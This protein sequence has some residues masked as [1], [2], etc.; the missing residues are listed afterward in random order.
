M[1]ISFALTEKVH[2]LLEIFF[3]ENLKVFQSQSLSADYTEE[4]FKPRIGH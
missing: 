1:S 3:S 4:F 2:V